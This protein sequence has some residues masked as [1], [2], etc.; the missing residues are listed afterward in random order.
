MT[1]LIPD[2]IKLYEIVLK[3][4][5][6]SDLWCK[7]YPVKMYLLFNLGFL[8]QINRM[9]ITLS[10]NNNSDPQ[11]VLYSPPFSWMKSAK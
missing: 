4:M 1:V 8:L 3:T 2:H 6:Y 7:S 11:H 9:Y 5:D 10:I